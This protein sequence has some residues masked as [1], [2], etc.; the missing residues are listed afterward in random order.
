M[1]RTNVA[2]CAQRI[3]KLSYSLNKNRQQ[4]PMT[5]ERIENLSDDQEESIEP[6]AKLKISKSPTKLLTHSGAIF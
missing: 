6:L 2:A 3:K 5:L 4:F 1:L